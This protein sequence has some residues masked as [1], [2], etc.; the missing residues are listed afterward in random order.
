MAKHF[1]QHVHESSRTMTTRESRKQT[2]FLWPE[3]FLER[4]CQ[5]QKKEKERSNVAAQ[6]DPDR[7]L[8]DFVR[9]CLPNVGAGRYGSSKS[10]TNPS[11]LHKLAYKQREEK[12]AEK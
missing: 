6:A 8:V 3:A 10:S 2:T 12:A 4:D 11:G 7:T 1:P 9:R 5:A